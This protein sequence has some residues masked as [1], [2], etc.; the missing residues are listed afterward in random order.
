MVKLLKSK[1]G[2]T[3]RLT[4]SKYKDGKLI[5]EQKEENRVVSSAGHGRNLLIRQ[6]TGDT[7]YGLE[8]DE[9]KIGTGT[10]APVDGDTDLETAVLSNITVES[11]SFS[12]DEATFSFFILD[13]DLADGTYDEFGLFIGGQL[14]ARSVFTNSFS[15]SAGEN[16]RVDYTLTLSAS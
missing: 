7:T 4:I 1:G 16:T 9:G 14:L 5:S 12:N 11:T 6:L 10:T 13:G 3:G 2:M 8:V 15:K